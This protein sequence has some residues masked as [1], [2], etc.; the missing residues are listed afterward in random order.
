M[1][2]EQESPPYFQIS[3][4]KHAPWVV[5][6]ATVFLIYS[7]MAVSA[8]I[9]SRLHLASVK[10]YDWLIAASL[11]IAIIQTFCTIEA[12]KHGLGQH[13]RALSFGEYDTFSKVC[14][15]QNGRMDVLTPARHH[16]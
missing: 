13:R 5:V 12:C 9:L 16:G 1:A 6:T 15:L 7:V 8:K 11:V 10:L 2:D 4:D 3:S 14:A